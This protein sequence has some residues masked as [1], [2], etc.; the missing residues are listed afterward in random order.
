MLSPPTFTVRWLDSW[1][2]DRQSSLPDFHTEQI[3]DVFFRWKSMIIIIPDNQII[4]EVIHRNSYINR[5]SFCADAVGPEIAVS[6]LVQWMRWK[7][8]DENTRCTVDGCPMPRR[9]RILCCAHV[10]RTVEKRARDHFWTKIENH[11]VIRCATSWIW[12]L[13]LQLSK[14]AYLLLDAKKNCTKLMQIS[15]QRKRRIIMVGKT[16]STR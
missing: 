10:A 6:R 12:L 2:V 4:D 8:L 16:V 13:H 7:N 5:Q 3:L 9:R 15:V 11:L 1:Q 14:R